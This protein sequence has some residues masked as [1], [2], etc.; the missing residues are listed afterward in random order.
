[1]KQLDF[2]SGYR[3]VYQ[4]FGDRL[5]AYFKNKSAHIDDCSYSSTR[6]MT[7]SA[8]IKDSSANSSTRRRN[9]NE[10]KKNAN[11]SDFSVRR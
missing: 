1:M 4:F 5:K 9:P 7:R 3:K 11:D 10:K 6:P 8:S 2:D